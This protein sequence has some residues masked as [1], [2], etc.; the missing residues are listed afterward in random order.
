[1]E[2]PVTMQEEAVLEHSAERRGGRARQVQH[3]NRPN[4]HGEIARGAQNLKEGA[5]RSTRGRASDQ[6]RNISLGKAATMDHVASARLRPAGWNPA[7]SLSPRVTRRPSRF[8][9]PVSV[10]QPKIPGRS[11]TSVDGSDSLPQKQAPQRSKATTEIP[12]IHKFDSS[13]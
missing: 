5:L 2:E 7:D 8:T 11:P 12:E 9:R 4:S 13:V 1:M 6:G 3:R 10:L